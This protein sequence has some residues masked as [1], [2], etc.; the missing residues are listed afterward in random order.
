MRAKAVLSSLFFA[1]TISALSPIVS[2]E[3]PPPQPSPGRQLE[4]TVVKGKQ[5]PKLLNKDSNNYSLMAVI[6]DKLEAI[7]YQFDDK[8]TR[9]LT[10]VPG[11]KLPVD[12]QVDIIE[13]NDELAF[14][15]KDMGAIAT[16]EIR[17]ALTGNIISE[18][19]VTE[20]NSSRYVY[21]IEGNQERSDKT[22][23]SYDM[24]TGLVSTETYSLQLD[25]D[26]ILVWSDWNIK[27]LTDSPSAPNVLDTMKVRIHAR[28]GF[29]KATIH[30]SL[31]PI[32]TLAV[33][34]GP[35]RAVVEA[36]ASLSIL[37][38]NL[39]KAGVSTTFTSQ[40]IEYPVFAALPSAAGA[41]SSLDITVTLDHVDLDGSRYRTALGPE[42]PLITATKESGRL[43]ENYTMDLDNPWVS[44]SSGKN[45]DMY[46][47]FFHEDNFLPTLD[48]VYNDAKA[49][50]D[51]DKPER[52]KGS[53][54]EMGI[55]LSDIPV[56]LETSLHCNLYF[57]PDLWQGNNPEIAAN[58]ILNPA[59]VMVN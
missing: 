5:L 8:N 17:Q 23:A 53:N 56:G 15:Y 1:C 59:V 37:G 31:V 35:V 44:I 38:I 33:K 30:N 42:E 57:G 16:P 43:K 18:L 49:G 22:Y 48:A 58:D 46:F 50:S 52:Y 55:A 41:L 40:T 51:V 27:S 20:K 10:Y 25:P 19:E 24:E 12:G 13:E 4:V 45:W 2:A 28:L 29:I 21:I 9:G 54:T 36:D 7:P 14:M 34:N 6:G 26:N 3:P 32:S 11:G 39:A 47:F